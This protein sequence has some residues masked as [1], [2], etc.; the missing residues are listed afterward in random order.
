MDRKGR[1]TDNSFEERF[2]RTIKYDKIYLEFIENVTDLH[3]CCS[4][5]VS[6]TIIQKSMQDWTTRRRE[7]VQQCYI[8]PN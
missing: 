8:T 3:K 2:F 6:F 5:F 7:N 4:D 1:Y